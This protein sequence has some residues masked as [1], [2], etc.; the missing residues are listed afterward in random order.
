MG[1]SGHYK[2]EI[3]INAFGNRVRSLRQSTGKSIEEFANENS[4]EV[5]QLSRIERGEVNCTISYIY[6]LASIFDMTASELL[7]FE[8][9]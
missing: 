8:L 5:T 6:R 1:K 4:L 7:D 2:D 3:A 9:E